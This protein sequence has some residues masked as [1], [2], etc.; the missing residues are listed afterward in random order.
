MEVCRPPFLRVGITFREHA[1]V[2]AIRRLGDRFEIP[3]LRACETVR[4]GLEILAAHDAYQE[5][6]KLR[7]KVKF[8]I[9]L[10]E[11][12]RDKR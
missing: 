7:G 9:D 8:S 6:R 5:L 4:R 1:D 11:L 3:G 2:Y 12:R 10:D